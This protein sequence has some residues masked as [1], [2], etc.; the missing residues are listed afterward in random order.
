MAGE[1]YSFPA[2]SVEISRCSSAAACSSSG[3]SV[4]ISISWCCSTPSVNT[5]RMLLASTHGLLRVA[6]RTRICHANRPASPA[7]TAARPACSPAPFMTFPRRRQEQHGP[8]VG[9]A[10]RLHSFAEDVTQFT[11]GLAV[12]SHVAGGHDRMVRGGHVRIHPLKA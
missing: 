2:K 5:L 7:N 10:Q 4:V 3:P 8:A 12:G 11:N 9:R 1:G 6:L